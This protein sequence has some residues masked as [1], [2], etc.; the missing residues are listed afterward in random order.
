VRVGN[1]WAQARV[2]SSSVEMRHPLAENSAEVTLVDGNHVVQ[3]FS[4]NRSNQPLTKSIG[5][6]GSDRRFDGGDPQLL[7]RLVE[8][9]RKGAMSIVNEEAIGVVTRDGFAKLL[10][11]PIC[12]GMLGHIAVN[13]APRSD[14]DQQQ[15][16]EDTQPDGDCDHEIAGDDRLGMIVDEGVC[17]SALAEWAIW[18]SAS[19]LVLCGEKPGCRASRTT[20]RRRVLAPQVG[21]SRTI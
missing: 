1:T 6:R 19:R 14:F 10:Q 15:Y 2:W 12:G 7:D 18:G 16:I 17:Q 5:L 11:S 4:S 8:L 13:D 21:F 9:G 20:H 3:T